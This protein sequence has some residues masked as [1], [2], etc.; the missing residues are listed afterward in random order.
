MYH[1]YFNQMKDLI[2]KD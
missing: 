2:T 1:V